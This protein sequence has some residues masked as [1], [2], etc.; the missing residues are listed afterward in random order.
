MITALAAFERNASVWTDMEQHMPFLFEMAKGDILEIGVRQGAS[1]SA[2]LAGVEAN[3]GH[4]WSVDINPCKIFSHPQW[5]FIQA[6]SIADKK[7]VLESVPD[8]LDLL[9]VDGDHT[10]E[11]CLSDLQTYGPLAKK[12]LIHD[13]LCPDTFPG[14]RKASEE[15]AWAIGKPLTIREGS[16]GLGVIECL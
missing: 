1:T 12:I 2:L 4:L 6:D 10:Y 13:C 8:E 14:V 11:G 5:T 3:G 16:Y 9:F 15:Y 7:R